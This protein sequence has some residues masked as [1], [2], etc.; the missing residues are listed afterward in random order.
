MNDHPK[1][2][3]LWPATVR[4]P[5]REPLGVDLSTEVC[6]IG[7]GIAG[8]T[9]AYRLACAGRKVVVVEARAIGAGETE[10]TTAHLALALDDGYSALA[11]VHGAEG[12]ALAASSHAAAIDEIERI[13]TEEGIDCAFERVDGYLF[14]HAPEALASIMEEL[15]ASQHAGIAGVELVE[16]TPLL[17][18]GP[19][20]RYPRQGQFHPLRYLAGLAAA[21]ERAGAKIFCG[22]AVAEILGG[23]PARVR[24]ED[25]R[26]ITAGAVVIATNTPFNERLVIHA[27]QEAYRTYVVAASVSGSLPKGLYW[28]TADPYH[29]ARLLP[30]IGEHDTLL[31]GGEDHKMGEADDLP[32]VRYDRLEAWARARIPSLGA[33][34]HRW[35]GQV[36]ATSDGLAF[37]GRNPGDEPNVFV[38]TGD[39]GHG[40]TYGTI[41]G[42]MLPDLILG[43][44][45]PWENLYDPSRMRASTLKRWTRAAARS[46][47]RPASREVSSVAEIEP[48]EGAIMRRG[49]RKIAVYRSPDGELHERSAVCTH[50]GVTVAWNAAARTW[51]C[52]AHGSRFTATGELLEGPAAAP[53]DAV[54]P[55]RKT[56]RRSVKP[57]STRRTRRSPAPRPRTKI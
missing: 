35:S 43:R 48:G 54:A 2:L 31:V 22:T 37:I 14:P 15:H 12:A 40:M 49:A 50:L 17:P 57:R 26:V 24:T 19:A 51:D 29:Y 20:L 10:R 44:P 52:P 4:I 27:K 7:A 13:A 6:V 21:A 11:C 9:T 28:D 38:V 55:E 1:E 47:A 53:L 34:T 42:L 5:Y 41:A 36:V 39:C 33:I 56:R 25:G 3:P 8:L 46:A 32:S 18:D 30:G 45:H 16:R 23:E